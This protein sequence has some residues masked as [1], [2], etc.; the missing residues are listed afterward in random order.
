MLA[1]GAERAE[2]GVGGAAP[3]ARMVQCGD[4]ADPVD[5]VLDALDESCSASEGVEEGDGVGV[6]VGEC[7]LCGEYGYKCGGEQGGGGYG[8]W[9]IGPPEGHGK[10]TGA[11]D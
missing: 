6:G 7:F 8:R 9:G 2:E 5:D 3:Q 4:G 11:R 1:Q 10:L